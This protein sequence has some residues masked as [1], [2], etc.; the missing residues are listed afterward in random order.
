[1]FYAK[2][3]RQINEIMH[4]LYA[5]QP[6]NLDFTYV[7]SYEDALQYSEYLDQVKNIRHMCGHMHRAGNALIRSFCSYQMS[8]CERFAQ[9]SQDR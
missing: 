9:I 4:Q 3:E 7:G 2:V 8:Y 5:E 6:E 1:M